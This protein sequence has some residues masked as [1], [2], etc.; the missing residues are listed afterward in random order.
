MLPVLLQ[1]RPHKTRTNYKSNGKTKLQM[2]LSCNYDFVF[3]NLNKNEAYLASDHSFSDTHQM[4]SGNIVTFKCA[5]V[6]GISKTE[7]FC[8]LFLVAAASL[9][10]SRCRL[11]RAVVLNRMGRDPFL[12]C[13]VLTLGLQNLYCSSI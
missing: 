5:E 8:L 9:V 7:S 6:E 13:K 11:F 1:T 10:H 4:G 12:S 3:A 2:L